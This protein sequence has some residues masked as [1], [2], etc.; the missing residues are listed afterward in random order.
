MTEQPISKGTK[1]QVCGDN[2]AIVESVATYVVSGQVSGYYVRW[3]KKGG[4]PGKRCSWV[5]PSVV[6]AIN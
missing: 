4:S 2:L 1:V 3:L 5:D 6:Q